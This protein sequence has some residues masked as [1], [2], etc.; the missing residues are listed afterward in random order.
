MSDYKV[1]RIYKI[2]HNQSNIC[3]IGSTFNTLRD[4]WYSHKNNYNRWIKDIQR[5]KSTIYPY[6]KQYGIENF[7]IVIIKEYGVCDRKHLEVYE[8]LWITKLQSINRCNTL[9]LKK[10]YQKEYQ[11]KNK[12]KIK[13]TREKYFDKNKELIRAKDR[14]RYKHEKER[15]ILQGKDYYEK[16]KDK[17]KEYRHKKINCECGGKYQPTSKA[18]HLKTNKHQKFIQAL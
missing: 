14:S 17:I 3:Y 2:I 13:E 12:D 5:C 15:R 4:R 10:L 7:K 6:F 18:K 16:N 11:E 9:C 1:G 8:Q